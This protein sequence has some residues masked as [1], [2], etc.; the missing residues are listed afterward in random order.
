MGPIIL[1]QAGVLRG[2]RATCESVRTD[3]R[4]KLQEAGVI[5][6][7]PKEAVVVSGRIVTGRDESVAR[8]FAQKLL[9]LVRSGT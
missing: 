9:E 5:L 4:Q 2:Q 3:S 6:A 8:E 1:A 7:D